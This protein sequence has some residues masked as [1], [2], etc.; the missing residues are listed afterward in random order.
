LFCYASIFE[1]TRQIIRTYIFIDTKPKNKN[2]LLNVYF[3]SEVTNDGAILRLLISQLDFACIDELQKKIESDLANS[4]KKFFIF[5]LQKVDTLDSIAL[6]GLLGIM[7]IASNR[8]CKIVLTQINPQIK[9]AIE[10]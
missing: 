2:R 7:K 4:E 6:S 10:I 1:T 9:R 5:D 3:E 8:G